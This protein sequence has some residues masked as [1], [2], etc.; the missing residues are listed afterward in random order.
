VPPNGDRSVT[1]RAPFGAWGICK[2]RSTNRASSRSE[3]HGGVPGNIH[4]REDPPLVEA[5]ALTTFGCLG[6]A[7][8]LLA[9]FLRF[10]RSPLETTPSFVFFVLGVFSIRG[11]TRA[12]K[13][14]GDPR[15]DRHP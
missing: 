12:W 6:L 4:L 15:A 10:L 5:Y 7:G 11:W 2:H 8:G 9:V 14:R 1:G 13:A 3:H